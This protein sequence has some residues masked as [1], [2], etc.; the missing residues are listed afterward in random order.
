MTPSTFTKPDKA[1]LLVTL[2]VQGDKLRVKQ[3]EGMVAT[4]LRKLPVWR[5]DVNSVHV[6]WAGSE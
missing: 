4:A 5:I 3:L 1:R 2:N 6:K